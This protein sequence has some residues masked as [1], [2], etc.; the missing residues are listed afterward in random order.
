MPALLIGEI[1]LEVNRIN[2]IMGQKFCIVIILFTSIPTFAQEDSI[3]V[4]FIGNY[5]GEKFRVFWEGKLILE[6]K[7]DR[8]YKYT[9]Q[10]PRDASWIKKGYTNKFVI[11]RRAAWGFAYKELGGFNPGYEPKK[12]LIIW[13][14]PRLKNRAAIQTRWS[15]KEPDV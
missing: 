3:K 12:Y 14:N 4:F 13:R 9:F 6:F 15:D 5:P 1:L 10:V 7:G 11:Y 8:S 2:S